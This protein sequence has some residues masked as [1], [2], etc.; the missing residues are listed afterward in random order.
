MNTLFGIAAL[1]MSMIV[2]LVGF[3][4][5]IVI[6]Y[7]KKSTDGFSLIFCIA[8]FLNSIAWFFYGMS[9]P[10]IDWFIVL[11]NVPGIVFLSMLLVQFFIYGKKNP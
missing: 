8:A 3:P 7:K 6:N 10:E 2:T 5:Q 11:A 4:S 1:V 9:K